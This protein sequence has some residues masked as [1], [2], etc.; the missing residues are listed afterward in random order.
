MIPDS[1][2][3]SDTPQK[4]YSTGY[5]L[6]LANFLIY[7]LAIAGSFGD[8]MATG[9]FIVIYFIPAT[10]ASLFIVAAYLFLIKKMKE[11]LVEII[12]KNFLLCSLI[13]IFTYIFYTGHFQYTYYNPNLPTSLFDPRAIPIYLI[14]LH[15]L[16]IISASFKLYL[17]NKL[18]GLALPLKLRLSL[19]S[20]FIIFTSL[21]FL[22]WYYIESIA[23]YLRY[24]FNATI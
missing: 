20:S 18:S 17:S 7:S 24:I 13:I 8:R 12:N 15:I 16:V 11:S 9:I 10:F 22:V 3:T 14:S 5:I 2:N 23:L 19:I 6:F 21:N 4:K 1:Q